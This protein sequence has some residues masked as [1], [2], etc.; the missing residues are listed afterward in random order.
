MA[1]Q[2]VAER[3]L[4]PIVSEVSHAPGRMKK[5]IDAEEVDGLLKRIQS[6]ANPVRNLPKGLV[7]IA[8][9]AMKSKAP[10][11]EVIHLILGGFLSNIVRLDGMD[12]FEG[13][14]IDPAE[15]KSIVFGIMDGLSPSGSLR[16]NSRPGRIGMGIGKGRPVA[17]D[18]NH[19]Q[20]KRSRDLSVSIG[21]RRCIPCG[22]YH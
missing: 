16:A 2:L 4:T 20:A 21:R 11:V 10:A 17:R 9:A 12:G 19:V 7:D 22:I 6:V 15:T 13:I 5:A 1:E 8:T 18:G 14:H 3:I